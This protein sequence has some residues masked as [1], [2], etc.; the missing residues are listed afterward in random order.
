MLS[1]GVTV[2]DGAFVGAG[3]VVIPGLRIGAAAVV[4]AGA[5]VVDDVAGGTTVLGVPARARVGVSR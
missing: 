4:A 2:E 5:V 3:A 1:G